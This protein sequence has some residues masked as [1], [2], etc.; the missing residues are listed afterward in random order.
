M[1]RDR[2]N[3][4][5]GLFLLFCERTRGCDIWEETEKMIFWA[6]FAFLRAY[7]PSCGALSCGATSASRPSVMAAFSRSER[8]SPSDCLLMIGINALSIG[9]MKELICSRTCGGGWGGRGG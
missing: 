9:S 5:L 8:L 7:P 4:F 1:G 6:F 3:D 2:K